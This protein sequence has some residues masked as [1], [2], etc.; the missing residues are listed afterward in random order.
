MDN[1]VHIIHITYINTYTLC[2]MQ[3]WGSLLGMLRV[4]TTNAFYSIVTNSTTTDDTNI[5][6]VGSS[7]QVA[8][9]AFPDDMDSSYVLNLYSTPILF[10]VLV[11]NE[12]DF[13]LVPDTE[14]IGFSIVG[15]DNVTNTSVTI[16]LQSLL[17]RQGN[18]TVSSHAVVLFHH[19][20]SFH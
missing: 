11:L 1:Y 10:P 2:M 20:L 13:D 5:T 8:A 18:Q 9:D 15:E 17:G 6:I 14:V 16:T 12:S 4:S 3:R 7:I 19:H